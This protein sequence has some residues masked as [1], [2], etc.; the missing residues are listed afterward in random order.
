M[1]VC[2]VFKAYM[3]CSGELC[4]YVDVWGREEGGEEANNRRGAIYLS[5]PCFVRSGP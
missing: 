5:T 2:T 4:M 3:S 1:S